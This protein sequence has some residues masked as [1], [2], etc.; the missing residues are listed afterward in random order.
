M[1]LILGATGAF[2]GAVMRELLSRGQPVRALVRDPARVTLPPGVEVVKGDVADLPG[3]LDAAKG[4][5]SIIHGVNLPYPRWYTEML[6]LHDH[7]VEAS[8]LTGATLVF[9]GNIYGLKPVYG[10]PLPWNAPQFDSMDKAIRKGVLR[11]QME[12]QLEQNTVLRN[13]RTIIVRA[14]DYFGPGVDNGL[15]T[16]MV[17]AARIGGGF[18]WPG[19]LDVGHAFT[20]I[21]DA[22]SVAVGMLLRSDPP[23]SLYEV[24]NVHGHYVESARAWAEALG[25]ASGRTVKARSLPFWQVR[26]AGVFSP[27]VREF[28][29]LLYQWEGPLLLD[30]SR[31]RALLPGWQPVP[32]HDALAAWVAAE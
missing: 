9:P 13:V 8:G 24:V 14:G 4:C 10:V 1:H 2:G 17:Q 3:L 21:G 27:V 19:R 16:P 26:L 6:R 5:E 23:S 7:V 25:K 30:D 20:Y 11:I 15:V 29:E 31:T 32:L 28:A 22:A 12:A 18:P